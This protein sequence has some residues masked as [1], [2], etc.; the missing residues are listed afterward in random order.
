MVSE[1][2]EASRVSV[3]F[4]QEGSTIQHDSVD[5]IGSHFKNLTLGNLF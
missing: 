5:G 4:R 3:G 1:T 2:T